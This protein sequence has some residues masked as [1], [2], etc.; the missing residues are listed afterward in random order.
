MN[1]I[2]K[3]ISGIIGIVILLLVVM[4]IFNICPPKGNWPAP[5]W[6]SNDTNT[7]LSN[8]TN[9]QN[10][11]INTQSNNL[12]NNTQTDIKKL[13]PL[14]IDYNVTVSVPY[15]TNNDVY[16]GV[17][18]NAEFLKLNKVNNTLFVGQTKLK[19]NS[20]YYYSKGSK[21]TTSLRTY[22]VNEVPIGLDSVINW[23]DS[24]K[25]I[26]KPEFQKG[27]TFGGMLW[28]VDYLKTP[29]L[30]EYNLDFVKK[31]GA[32]YIIII[33]DWYLSDLN[34]TSIFPWYDSN[35]VFPNKTNWVK[36]TLTDEQ[37][38]FIISE[39][40]K[41]NLK[42]V[43]KP[44]VDPI[45]WS[46]EHPKGRGDIQP[47]NWDEWYSSYSKFIMHYAKL[48]EKDNV[49]LFVV[50]TE[51]DPA[52]A[53]AHS[54]GPKDG[55][56]TEYFENL[57]KDIKKAYSGKLTYSV[58]CLGDECWGPR[59]I[60]FWDSLDY[61]GFEPYQSLSNKMDPSID[62]IKQGFSKELEWARKLHEQY[63]KPVLF[64]EIAS[65]SNDGAAK[66]ML[67]TPPVIKQDLFEQADVYEAMFQVIENIDWV[68]GMYPW[69]LYL[70]KS[71][72]N[73]KWQLKDTSSAFIAKPAGQVIEKWY[74]EIQ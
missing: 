56:Q 57:I 51:I 55:G 28:D 48:A 53:E 3:I 13:E 61:I 54:Y 65:P 10:I 18:D 50:G 72:N 11:D 64:T 38:D 60:K 2:I 67:D 58:A 68:Q 5:P 69:A 27:V 74:K 47:S 45:M 25:I 8:N 70:V 19:K 20:V 63:N 34:S 9:I 37:I 36:P 52:A 7:S 42:I 71:D 39:A 29:G 30:I 6:C 15:W 26:N 43:L 73:L 23:K 41:R 17:D 31:L 12:D 32:N 46:P 16:L 40:R 21:D 49:E 35:G 44:H 22:D 33:P 66:Y 14:L 62:E 4:A 24:V 59:S 1:K